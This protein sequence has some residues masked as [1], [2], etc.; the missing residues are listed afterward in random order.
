MNWKFPDHLNKYMTIQMLTSMCM[1]EPVDVKF[2][3]L[4]DISEKYCFVFRY[5][6]YFLNIESANILSH[7]S[8]YW[9][10]IKWQPITPGPLFIKRTEVVPPNLVNSQRREIGCYNNRITLKIYRHIGISAAD[11]PDKFQ[12]ERK[13]VTRVPQLRDFTRSWGRTSCRVCGHNMLPIILVIKKVAG[14]LRTCTSLHSHN[15]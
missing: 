13:S 1:I 3:V 2:N 15:N 11:V 6:A 9:W 5:A 8:R 12:S 7:P 14:L 4:L 10:W